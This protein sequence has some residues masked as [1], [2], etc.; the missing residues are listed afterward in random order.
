MLYCARRPWRAISILM[1]TELGAP[2]GADNIRLEPLA[3]WHRA[4]LKAACAE[5][6]EIWP[7]Y[8]TS[9]DPDHFDTQF[10]ALR[11][12]EHTHAFAVFKDG[13]L[14]GMTAFLGHRSER[15]TV[16]IGNTYYVPAVRG[17]GFNRRVK[18]LLLDRAFACDIRR[19]E[20]RVDDRNARSKAAVRKLGASQDG[21][22]RA[23]RITWTGHV[24]D[25]ALFS[26]LAEEWR[27]LSAA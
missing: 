12:R 26:I 14:V 1:T 4:D 17:T 5:D 23:E 7:I 16:E 24:R 3:E 22:L 2:L 21:L 9:W 18:T 19:V 15:Q 6:L 10:D 25:T 13:R 11:A 20:F 27:N 8:G